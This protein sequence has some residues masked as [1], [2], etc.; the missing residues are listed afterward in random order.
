MGTSL[1]T[2]LELA[3]E[4]RK[5]NAQEDNRIPYSDTFL[6]DMMSFFSRETAQIREILEV[7]REAK[8]IFIIKVVLPDA[9]HNAKNQDPGVDAYIYADS[10][11]VSDLRSYSEKK[12]E[13]AYEAT[14]YKRKSPFQITRELFP[15][16]KEHNNTPLGRYV[17]VVVML[18]EYQRVLTAAPNEYEDAR[19]RNNLAA[20]LEQSGTPAT[21]A[22]DIP[23]YEIGP[24]IG[25]HGTKRAADRVASN[26]I[27]INPKNPW[28]RLTSK[29][30]SEFLIRIHLRKYEFDTVKKLIQGGKIAE[31]DE[32]K[33]VRDTL[34]VMESHV[35]LDPLLNNFLSE[36]TELRRLAQKKMNILKGITNS[37]PIGPG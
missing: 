33:F 25:S 35:H 21:I 2:A 34:Q 26:E 18:E 17:N 14:Y 4:I 29:F 23:E 3:E 8:Y 32:L 9:A 12:L 28:S 1:A 6:K 11:I 20:L 10:K 27:L 24:S 30:S 37:G 22:R 16:I 19:R 31:Y 36:M 7:L 15:K 5:V 13:K